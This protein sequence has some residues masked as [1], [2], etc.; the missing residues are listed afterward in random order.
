[1]EIAGPRMDRTSRTQPGFGAQGSMAFQP[2]LR[3][4]QNEPVDQDQPRITR[5]Y[6]F[7]PQV[8]FMRHVEPYTPLFIH[9]SA[10]RNSNTLWTLDLLRYHMQT[11]REKKALSRL[12]AQRQQGVSRGTTTTIVPG[13]KRGHDD[14]TAGPDDDEFLATM[15]SV[16]QNVRFAGVSY[17]QPSPTGP[18]AGTSG[19]VSQLNVRRQVMPIAIWGDAR[20]PDLFTK[21]VAVG[22]TLWMIIKPV[23]RALASPYIN[24][25]GEAP[26]KST[27]EPDDLVIDVIF[28]THA[29]NLPPQRVSTMETLRLLE[30][31]KQPPLECRQYIDVDDDGEREICDAMVIEFATVVQPPKARKTLTNANAMSVPSSAPESLHVHI[32]IKPR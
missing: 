29:Q 27:L 19:A 31:G 15:A 11:A 30:A 14:L 1:M 6:L 23:P 32:N 28:Y 9:A 16:M 17:G 13:G 3:N 22:Q 8:V 2:G 4:G 10:G 7:V 12:H 5:D 21:P 25:H 18:H 20:F 24:V 26:M